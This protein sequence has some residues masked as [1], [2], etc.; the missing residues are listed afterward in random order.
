LA[1]AGEME[2]SAA[3]F[4]REAEDASEKGNRFNDHPQFLQ[5]METATALDSERASIESR[6][7]RFWWERAAEC[8]RGKRWYER[9]AVGP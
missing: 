9:A 2:T 6:Q 7:T 3:H 8:A 1:R 4:Q 5:N